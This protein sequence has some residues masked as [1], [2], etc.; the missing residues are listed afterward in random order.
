MPAPLLTLALDRPVSSVM[1][2]K[3]LEMGKVDILKLGLPSLLTKPEGSTRTYAAVAQT[4]CSKLNIPLFLDFKL[5]DTPDTNAGVIKTLPK[6]GYVTISTTL[7][8]PAHLKKMV[9][10]C[11]QQE[12]QPVAVSLT[13]ATQT[14]PLVPSVARERFILSEIARTVE[15]GFTHFVCDGSILPRLKDVP[16]STHV[17]GIRPAWYT[18]P[19]NHQHTIE[20]AQAARFG[21]YSAIVGRPVLDNEERLMMGVLNQIRQDLHSV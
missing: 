8:S 21:A 20:P 3:L 7:Y 19:G 6:G 5:A 2:G 17:P 13:T 10:L 14:H 15:C 1:L 11:N 16:I 9:A 4:L 12:V 18:E